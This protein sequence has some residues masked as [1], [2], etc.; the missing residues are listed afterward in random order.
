MRRVR[1][2]PR[3]G[4]S[5]G[6]G[7]APPGRARDPSPSLGSPSG[8]SSG[9]ALAPPS[10]E[11]PSG[12]SSA[13]PEAAETGRASRPSAEGSASSPQANPPLERAPGAQSLEP[14]LAELDRAL[15]EDEREV[16]ADLRARIMAASPGSVA[17]AEAAFKLGLYRLFVLRDPERAVDAL[18]AAVRARQPPWS[19]PAR[20]ALAQLLLR[21]GKLQQAAFELRKASAE[22]PEDLVGIQARALLADALARLGQAIEAEAVRAALKTALER[23][24][25]VG[26]MEAGIAL[27]W[28]GFEHKHDGARRAAKAAFEAA[29]NEDALPPE[30][31]AAIERALLTL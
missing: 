19:R 11:S 16:A 1:P 7:R 31:R 23:L 26:G 24:G 28:L 25:R 5:R 22:G 29:L 10:L 27:A 14:L 3:P 2:R 18:R 21:Q 9:G 8:S 20:I 15:A 12:S 30:E 4:A 13:P 6:S 17:G